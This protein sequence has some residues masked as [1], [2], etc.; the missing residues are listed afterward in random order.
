MLMELSLQTG[1]PL[2]V[3]SRLSEREL[4]L[5][6]RYRLQKGFPLRRI[7]LGLAQIAMWIAQTMGGIEGA[8]LKEFLFDPPTE[9]GEMTEEELE[10]LKADIVFNPING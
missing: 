2:A 5:W 8:S 7:E 3:I 6:D 4:L 1:W 10:E 9:E